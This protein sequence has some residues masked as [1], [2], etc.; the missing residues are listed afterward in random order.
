[1]LNKFFT[2]L[3]I[4]T[5]FVSILF[6]N[7]NNKTKTSPS[8]ADTLPKVSAKEMGITGSF[9]AQTKIKFDSAIIKTFLDSFPKFKIFK[10]DITNFYKSRNYAYAWYDDKGMIEPANNLYN[11]IQNISDE[12][13]PDAVPY[14]TAFTTLMET[15]EGS[16]E[17]A[18]IVEPV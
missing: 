2:P 10:K 9:S 1:M 15:E 16:N 7:C 3:F 18:P 13:I 6:T 14:K 4:V 11:R 12:G 17:I 8:N 5:L